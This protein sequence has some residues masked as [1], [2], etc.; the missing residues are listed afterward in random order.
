MLDLLRKGD[1]IGREPTL[2][3]D[4]VARMRRAVLGAERARPPRFRTAQVVVA[5][6]LSLVVGLGAWVQRFDPSRNPP[7]EPVL[8]APAAAG[9]R[10]QL[11]F[12]TPGGTRVIWVFDSNFNVR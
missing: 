11:Q 3:E 9:E 2:G 8:G 1:P 12:A 10:R 4:E 6:L 5:A 7:A